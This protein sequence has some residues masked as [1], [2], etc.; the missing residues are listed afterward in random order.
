[1]P[2]LAEFAVVNEPVWFSARP[3]AGESLTVHN[4]HHTRST[5]G[6]RFVAV[7]EVNGQPSRSWR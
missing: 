2:S 5:A 1:M 6:L 7:V 4:R 3:R